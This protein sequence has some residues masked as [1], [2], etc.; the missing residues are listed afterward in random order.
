[1]RVG[2]GGKAGEEYRKRPSS[3]LAKPEQ[4]WEAQ[5]VAS[6]DEHEGEECESLSDIEG[7][8]DTPTPHQLLLRR[9]QANNQA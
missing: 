7:D 2:G 4:K 8:T 3:R 1:M 5:E 6:T 9:L